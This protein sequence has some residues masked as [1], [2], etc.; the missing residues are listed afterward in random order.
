MDGLHAGRA[1]SNE[2]C[3]GAKAEGPQSDDRPKVLVAAQEHEHIEGPGIGRS[4]RRQRHS[5]PELHVL[6]L[7]QTCQSACQRPILSFSLQAATGQK[8]SGGITWFR[9]C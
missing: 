3:Q 4:K 1:Q 8:I 7:Q 6:H 5:I 2:G 9:E